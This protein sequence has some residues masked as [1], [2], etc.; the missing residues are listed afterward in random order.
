MDA[1]QEG[2][3]PFTPHVPS[4]GEEDA[5]LVLALNLWKSRTCTFFGN[6]GA[7]V[8][9]SPV[10]EVILDSQWVVNGVCVPH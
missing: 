7:Y 9:S 4:R 1:F 2:V 10:H 6:M 5:R 3:G 8:P